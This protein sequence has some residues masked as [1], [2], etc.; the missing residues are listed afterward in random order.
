MTEPSS[1]STGS[2]TLFTNPRFAP[3]F[4]TQFWGAFNDNLF[5]N[6]LVLTITFHGVAVL[7]L[8]SAQLVALA[9]GIFIL[10]FFLFSALA[11]ELADKYPKTRLIRWVKLA[12]VA[13]MLLGALGFV[14]HSPLFLLTVLFSM[15]LHSTIFGPLKYG[16]LPEL[17]GRSQLVGGNALVELGTF[18]AILLGTIGAGAALSFASGTVAGVACVVVALLGLWSA[19]RIPECPAAAPE[20]RISR[21]LFGPTWSLVRI[22]ARERSVL[23]SILG[24]SW[25]WLLGAVVLS[26][27]PSLVSANLGGKEALVT[28]LLALFSVGVGS[29][30][31]L[32]K[33]FSFRQLELGLVPLGSLGMTA[34]LLDTALVLHGHQAI[35]GTTI[36]SLLATFDG[37][38]LSVDLLGFALTSGLFIVPLYT[39]LQER[40]AE[41][42]RARAIAANNVVNAGFM[43]LGSL[44]LTGFHALGASIPVIVGI[45]AL[46]N[47][48]VALYIYTVIPEFL[49]RFVC[50]CL[51]HFLYRLEVEGRDHIPEQGPAVLVCNH[52][53]FVDWL[54][55]SAATQRPI[56]F[57][58]YYA[59]T[60]L[61]LTGRIFRDA[62]V[63]PIAGAKEAPEIL[64]RAFERIAEELAAGELVCI[65]P[66]GKL[67]T[68]G[69]IAVFKRG[70]ERI[71]ER[72]P[73]PVVPMHLH[74]LW[75]SM[76][77]KRAPRR[78]FG[79]FLARITLRVG[80]AE[81]PGSASAAS[82]QARVEALAAS[83][84]A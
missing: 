38:R 48:V 15:G 53:T 36:G 9:G 82:L 80:S 39:L 58:M 37:L 74:G 73:V 20:L 43:V 56:R 59:F 84:K 1:P 46:L 13:I 62:K 47:A 66:E 35:P 55:I 65:F 69:E 11:G 61:P 52:V 19:S 41:S 29:G 78:L 23:H 40:T 63:I 18:L 51:A 25:F 70:I 7:G 44:M 22:A 57:V 83:A 32:C 42:V 21:G 28:Y 26:L 8:E 31:L 6:A 5:K 49:F 67:T 24:I 10:P 14:F 27:L 77:S 3:L 30:S 50:Y 71:V 16:I 17:I 79:R 12:E 45:V 60:R 72:T 81:L 64:E 75:G 76:F 54:V 33:R 2:D 4:W 34:F 68:D